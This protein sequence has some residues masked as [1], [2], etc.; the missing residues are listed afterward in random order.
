LIAEPITVQVS[1]SNPLKIALAL[2]DV[3]LL[4]RFV[5]P[6]GPTAVPVSNESADGSKVD[7]LAVT[8]QSIDQVLIEGNSTYK[9]LREISLK[10]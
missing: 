10:S 3:C 1:L 6:D 8:T 4:W 5:A 7:T 9:V 2:S